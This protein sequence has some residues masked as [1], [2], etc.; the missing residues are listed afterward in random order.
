MSL[1]NTYNCI[2]FAV[3]GDVHR[4]T[5]VQ[6]GSVRLHRCRSQDLPLPV[7]QNVGYSRSWSLM[8]FLLPCAPPSPSLF[9]SISLYISFSLLLSAI[10]LSLALRLKDTHRHT[11]ITYIL[12]TKSIRS[13]LYTSCMVKAVQ[14]RIA[15]YGKLCP[16][17]R[18]F[19]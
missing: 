5:T 16:S 12:H 9:I 11:F 15:S 14:N 17:I 19:A 13:G 8:G 6:A 2:E 1:Y 4:T 3:L 10:Y 18:T 7:P